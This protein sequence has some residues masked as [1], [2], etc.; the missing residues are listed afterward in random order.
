MKVF[1][2]VEPSLATAFLQA[3]KSVSGLE[4]V[5]DVYEAEATVTDKV[6]AILQ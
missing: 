6:E 5:E 4:W 1:L 3:G 2:K